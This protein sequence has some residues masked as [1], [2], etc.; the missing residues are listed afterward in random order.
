MNYLEVMKAAKGG[1]L[2][3]KVMQRMHPTC[4]GA[5]IH[6]YCCYTVLDVSMEDSKTP[7]IA[8]VETGPHVFFL[9][10]AFEMRSNP[11]S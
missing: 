2:I 6:Q 5:N 3:G 9:L 4:K 11:D 8:L 7:L 1:K 10:E